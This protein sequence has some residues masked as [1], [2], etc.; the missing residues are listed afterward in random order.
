[1]GFHV[2]LK[3]VASR[4]GSIAVATFVLLVSGVELDMAVPRALVLEETATELAPERE[5]VCMSLL[6]PL[7]IGEPGEGAITKGT[8]VRGS[9]GDAHGGSGLNVRLGC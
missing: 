4:K 1:M 2:N 7:E 5:L 9:L 3:V 6:M 8:L